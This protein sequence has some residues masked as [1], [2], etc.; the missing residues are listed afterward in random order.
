MDLYAHEPRP[1]YDASLVH[2]VIVLPVVVAGIVL[3]IR[4]SLALAFSLAGVVAAVRF[5]N[6]LR[7]TKDAVYIFLAIG[8]GLAAGVQA[9][10]SAF[11]MSVVFVLVVIALWRFNVG[12]APP[13]ARGLV[14]AD[15][16]RVAAEPA[17]AEAL[18]RHARRWKLLHEAPADDGRAILTYVVRLRRRTSINVMVDEVRRAAGPGAAIRFEPRSG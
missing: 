9:F 17:I 10:S 4:D 2:T 11:V 13:A 7:D 8:L 1:R 5:R 14:V 16:A 6:T 3:I 18:D 12:A 15:G